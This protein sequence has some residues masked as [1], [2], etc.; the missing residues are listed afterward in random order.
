MDGYE[1]VEETESKIIQKS[2]LI[3]HQISD[4]DKEVTE[5][6]M[7]RDIE[8]KTW[9]REVV[10]VSWL[11]EIAR[12]FIKEHNVASADFNEQLYTFYV[13]PLLN[14]AFQERPQI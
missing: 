11:S 13:Y 12:I 1:N 9:G 2:V 3:I 4:V 14:K 10:V 7:E 8:V 5:K 6:P